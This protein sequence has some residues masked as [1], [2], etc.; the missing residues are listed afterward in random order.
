MFG[1]LQADCWGLDPPE[2]A[3]DC[4]IFTLVAALAIRCPSLQSLSLCEFPGMTNETA[5]TLAA[6]H[7]PDLSD[8]WLI[9]TGRCDRT[10]FA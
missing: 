1:L 4:G 8:L 7:L 5:K 2:S 3:T 10:A 6:A 9:G